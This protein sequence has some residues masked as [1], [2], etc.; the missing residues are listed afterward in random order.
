MSHALAT[1]LLQASGVAAH[2]ALPANFSHARSVAH[3]SVHTPQMHAKPSLHVPSQTFKKCVSVSVFGP[4]P[5]AAASK[6]TSAAVPLLELLR[7]VGVIGLL[8]IASFFLNDALAAIDN[9]L[10]VRVGKRMR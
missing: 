1:S 5:Q 2:V 4:P 9:D 7:I 8:V 3:R 6:T 10:V